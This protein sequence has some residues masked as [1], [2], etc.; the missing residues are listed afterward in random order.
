MILTYVDSSVLISVATE[1]GPLTTEAIE[2]LDDQ[3]RRFA[4]SAYVKMEIYPAARRNHRRNEIALYDRFFREAVFPGGG[5]YQR[6]AELAVEIVS[7]HAVS[8]LDALH[9]ASAVELGA[10]EL[11]TVE[12]PGKGITRTGLIDVV[13][14]WE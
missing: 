3:E 1:R 10:D 14:L 8:P 5:G 6:A 9:I 11:V 7:R 4:S 13:S 2:I 12:K